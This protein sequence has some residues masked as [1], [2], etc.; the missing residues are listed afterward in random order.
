MLW[1][2]DGFI[3]P[4]MISDTTDIVLHRLVWIPSFVLGQLDGVKRA[5]APGTSLHQGTIS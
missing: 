4:L 2:V 5:R 1:L 3:M